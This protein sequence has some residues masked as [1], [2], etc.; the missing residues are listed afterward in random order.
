MSKINGGN[1]A[2][3]N[4]KG[5]S[6]HDYY[7]TPKQDTNNFLDLIFKDKVISTE[8]ETILEP[9]G[10]GGHMVD[11]VKERFPLATV[12]SLD[13]LP[14]RE[15]IAQGDFLTDTIEDKYDLVITNPPFKIAKE[16]INKSLS[17]S[18]RYVMMYLKLQFLEGKTRKEWFSNVPLKYVYVYSYRSN[19]MKNGKDRDENGKKWASTM[20]FAWFVFDKEYE[21]EPVVRWI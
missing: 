1:I 17:V 18:N 11:V 21:G 14:K 4:T 9:A 12:E 13:I 8:I 10:G 7:A 5:R 20:A 6:E 15:D 19:P 2:G 16:F 3:G